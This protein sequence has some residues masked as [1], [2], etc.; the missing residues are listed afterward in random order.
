MKKEKSNTLS[1]PATAVEAKKLGRPANANSKR[2]VTLAARAAAK[3]AGTFKKGRPS[4]AGSK[5]QA[6]LA[7][8]AEKIAAG[9]EVKRGR[10][11][12]EKTVVSDLVTLEQGEVEVD[13]LIIPTVKSKSKKK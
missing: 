1:A 7:A 12:V 8:R 9:I 4:V 3:E 2:Q 10:P 13:N 11:K 6:V 5:R